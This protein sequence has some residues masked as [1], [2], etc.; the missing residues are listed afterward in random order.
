M[1]VLEKLTHRIYGHKWQTRGQ[2]RYGATTYRVCLR[3]GQAQ[4]R[5]NSPFELDHFQNCE[6]IPELDVQFD[7]KGRYIYKSGYEPLGFLG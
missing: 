1:K 2:N 5:V 7:E 3:C 6:R 4:E